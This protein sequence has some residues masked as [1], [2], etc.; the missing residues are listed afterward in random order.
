MMKENINRISIIG[1]GNLATNLAIA[2]QTNGIEIVD[3]VSKNNGSAKKLANR[4]NAYHRETVGQIDTT[5]ELLIIAV[6]D[7]SILNVLTDLTTTKIPI[8]HTS[9]ATSIDIFKESKFKEFGVFYPVQSFDKEKLTNFSDLP[10]AIEASHSNLETQLLSLC[11]G[12]KGRAI[13]LNSEDRKVLH[14][15]AVFANNF[16]THLLLQS[17]QILEQRSLNIDLLQPL[18]TKTFS[19]LSLLKQTGPA[20]R[21]DKQIIEEHLS[22]LRGDENKADLY[23]I[24]TNSIIKSNL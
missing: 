21:E 16:T 4:V 24:L 6:T 15:A 11:R 5:T 8:V 22:F 1:A 17:K 18:I 3:I 9:G 19:D 23:K 10:I 20:A 7:D 2:F 14:I 12:I 13:K